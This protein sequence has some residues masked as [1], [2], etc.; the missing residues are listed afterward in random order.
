MLVSD[1][2]FELNGKNIL[3]GVS[4]NINKNDKIGLI[5][6]NG[7]GKTTLLNILSGNIKNN[8]KGNLNIDVDKVAILKQEIPFKYTKYSIIDYLKEVC[9]ISIL[10]KELNNFDFEN[11]NLEKY[12]MMLEKFESLDGYDFENKVIKY[13]NDLNLQKNINT[14]IYELSGGEKI[15]VLIIELFLKKSDI[16]LLDEPTNNLDS[17]TIKYLKNKLKN[18][19][20]SMLIVSHDED[21]LSEIVNRVFVLK[22]GNLSIY[23]VSYDEYLKLE[24]NEYNRNMQEYENAIKEKKILKQRLQKAKEWEN[25]G[26]KNKAN[27]DN[28]K[29]AN[30]YA[31]EKTKNSDISKLNKELSELNIPN[32]KYKQDLDY[33]FKFN[34]EKG[35]KDIIIS[36]LVCGYNNFKTPILNININFGD[37][38]SIIGSNGSGKTTLIKTL[39]GKIKPVSG[40]IK[41][42]NTVK[43]GYISKDTFLNDKNNKITIIDYIIEKN[44]NIDKTFVFNILNKFDIKYDDRNKQYNLL[45]PGE[46]ARVNLAKFAANNTNVIILDEPTNHLDIEGIRIMYDL[47]ESYKGTIISIS[48]NEKYN[49]LLKPNKILN[50]ETGEVIV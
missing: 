43:F 23:N 44:E 26:R 15:K 4:F 24:Q 19:N 42:G 49:K 39:I 5:G 7:S 17:K 12:Y 29:I 30:N 31:K 46:R 6:K 32:F 28:D 21:F 11:G 18:S 3:N 36:N 45:S 35:N 1:L 33:F 27:N 13:L 38:I 20:G 41:I 9:S 2:F 40:N 10:E 34:E 37:K 16:I 14:K 48:H 8:I 22:E 47:I 50:I 25:K